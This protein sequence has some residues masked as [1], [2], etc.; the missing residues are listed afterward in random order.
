M[1]IFKQAKNGLLLDYACYEISQV[2]AITFFLPLLRC[3]PL[4]ANPG[5][6]IVNVVDEIRD[7]YMS[8]S[9][10]HPVQYR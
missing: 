8:V 5:W 10:F 1:C 9:R 2:A 3:F 6:E 7:C 4:I